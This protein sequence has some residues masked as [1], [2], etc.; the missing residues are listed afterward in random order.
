[1]NNNLEQSANTTMYVKQ[2]FAFM[3]IAYSTGCFVLC[4]LFTDDLRLSL[5]AGFLIALVSLYLIILIKVLNKLNKE[6]S[7]LLNEEN[8]LQKNIRHEFAKTH[9]MK[10]KNELLIKAGAN[11]SDTNNPEKK[12]HKVNVDYLSKLK[13]RG[14]HTKQSRNDAKRS[15]I[16]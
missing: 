3:L 4:A 10:K 1:M 2:H 7:Q 9:K 11:R 12:P 14:V 5:V 13:N 16:G 15:T 8:E 6:K